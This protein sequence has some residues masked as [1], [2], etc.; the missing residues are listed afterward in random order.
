VFEHGGESGLD[1]V[2]HDHVVLAGDV[3]GVLHEVA[4]AGEL[5][6]VFGVEVEG[7]GGGAGGGGA[8]EEPVEFG[9]GYQ[10]GI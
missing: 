3:A 6:M 9:A 7:G 4:E 5:L 1:L 10:E 8:G 2:L